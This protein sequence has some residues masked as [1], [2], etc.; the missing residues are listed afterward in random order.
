MPSM[1]LVHSPHILTYK[2]LLEYVGN[3]KGD[4]MI[5]GELYDKREPMEAIITGGNYKE[6]KEKGK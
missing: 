3:D 2:W 1:V 6:E 5:Q 4:T